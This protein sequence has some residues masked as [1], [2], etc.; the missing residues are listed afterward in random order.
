MTNLKFDYNTAEFYVK[1][2]F[3]GKKTLEEYII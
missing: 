2:Q 1:A 3:V